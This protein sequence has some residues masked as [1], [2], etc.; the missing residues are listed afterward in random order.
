MEDL[1]NDDKR[2]LI[3]E[4]N[5]FRLIV[6]THLHSRTLILGVFNCHCSIFAIIISY[7]QFLRFSSL[8]G[9]CYLFVCCSCLDFWGFYVVVVVVVVVFVVVVVVVFV[10]L[11]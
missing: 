10:C 6:T 5:S 11:F 1:N 2:S 7:D 8:C 9:G 3:L 4:I